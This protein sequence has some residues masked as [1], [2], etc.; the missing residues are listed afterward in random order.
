LS[1][2]E[3]LQNIPQNSCDENNG[4]GTQL[5]KYGMITLGIWYPF[6]K[7]SSK[8]MFSNNKVFQLQ[9]FMVLSPAAYLQNIP[10]NSYDK[11]NGEGIQLKKY[12]MIT[13]GI[14]Y[15][16]LWESFFQ[17]HVLQQ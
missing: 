9:N 10:Q 13:L 17:K 16:T 7:V 15:L 14:C 5:Q 1:P 3:Y 6:E 8:N 12:G 4:K 11:N 2:A